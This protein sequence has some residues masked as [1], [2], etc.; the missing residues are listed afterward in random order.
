MFKKLLTLTGG[1]ASVCILSLAAI[2]S[3]H[4]AAV[5][6]VQATGPITVNDYDT[7]ID[8][9]TWYN[10]LTDG[11]HATGVTFTST[12]YIGLGKSDNSPF[13]IK[14]MKLVFA[15]ESNI[16]H[17]GRIRVNGT[18]YFHWQLNQEV[19]ADYK[20]VTANFQQT[21]GGLPAH[22]NVQLMIDAVGTMQ[23]III[24]EEIDTSLPSYAINL[25]M[26]A[27]NPNPAHPEC[28]E[29]GGYQFLPIY[30]LFDGEDETASRF[31][32][33][34][35]SSI[36]LDLHSVQAVHDVKLGFPLSNVSYLN[37]GEYTLQ[38]A[39]ADGIFANASYDDSYIDGI[40]ATT[41]GTTYQRRYMVF[42]TALQARF[43][44]LQFNLTA[45]RSLGEFSV[46]QLD[47][48]PSVYACVADESVPVQIYEGQFANLYDQDLTSYVW[49]N[50]TAKYVQFTYPSAV[51][52]NRAQVQ[53]GNA[54]GNDTFSGK[55]QAYVLGEWITLGTFADHAELQTLNF[56][57]VTATVYR[58]E[59]TKLS[60]WIAL[61]EFQL[62]NATRDYSNISF[63]DFASSSLYDPYTGAPLADTASL[64]NLLDGTAN[65]FTRFGN[66]S[67]TGHIDIEF[68]D[69]FTLTGLRLKQ[70]ATDENDPMFAGFTP[71][72]IAT[73]Q[74]EYARAIQ[75]ICTRSDSSTVQVGG[76]GFDIYYTLQTH[77]FNIN[78]AH[79]HYDAI[80]AHGAIADVKKIS[81]YITNNTGWLT[82]NELII[83]PEFDVDVVGMSWSSAFNNAYQNVDHMTDGDFSTA[84]FFD[85]HIAVGDYLQL[86][87]KEPTLVH[88]VLFFQVGPNYF[89]NGTGDEL[90]TP[91]MVAADNYL[92]SFKIETSLN[93]TDWTLVPNTETGSIVD[94]II[95]LTTPVLAKYVRIVNLSD[96][97]GSGTDAGL[98]VREF[99][100]NALS[101]WE[102]KFNECV[103]CDNG[104]T[105]PSS[106]GWL[107]AQAEFT[108]LDLT[109]QTYVKNHIA[110]IYTPNL[111]AV[112]ARYNYIVSKYGVTQY[113]NYIG[114]EIISGQGPLIIYDQLNLANSLSIL[115]VISL[116]LM[117]FT[118]FFLSAKRRRIK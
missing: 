19:T 13:T 96:A 24:N 105:P 89:V 41:A 102:E 100:V 75:V 51:T 48:H 86:N 74:A 107:L 14:S 61:H 57:P 43:I 69:A 91:T 29:V 23:E 33:T 3:N 31:K 54:S 22:T 103:V 35:T 111:D 47:Q 45:W 63:A 77:E 87:L 55:V 34:A 25:D 117:G 92:K 104:V 50:Q 94:F 37:S 80:Q 49:F 84:T 78:L 83:N 65:T 32:V 28:A 118:F 1:L 76:S 93:G 85:W 4:K 73:L 2:H 81:I 26:V 46:N 62:S 66:P 12:G 64:H 99:Q 58:L 72:Q 9:A 109:L 114:L 115:L 56:A 17:L 5:E 60:G 15:R 30:Q 97:S 59:N 21:G 90:P 6:E 108:A 36:T 82:L 88:D 11:D 7:T 52:A 16:A 44:R 101:T 106:A 68:T 70:A 10:T 110:S 8:G 53:T 98:T 42:P 95:E 67:G 113:P 38:Y 18:D 116:A 40:A 79:S 112:L 27:Y 71:T 20:I 39:G